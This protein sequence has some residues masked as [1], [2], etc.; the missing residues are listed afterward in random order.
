ME[1][2]IY[3]KKI[4]KGSDLP[5]PFTE[6]EMSNIPEIDAQNS[7]APLSYSA[8]IAEEE[9]QDPS[10]NQ[11]L[12]PSDGERKGQAEDTGIFIAFQTVGVDK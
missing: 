9:N 6:R 5:F 8:L 1:Y 3:P 2:G 10:G 11:S 7:V 4:L 12:S